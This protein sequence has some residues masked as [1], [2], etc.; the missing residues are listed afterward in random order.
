MVTEEERQW[1]WQ[2]Y[3]PEPRMRLN[4]GIRRRLAPLLD[5]DRRLIQLANSLLFSLPGTPIIYYGDEIGMGDDIWLF[6]RNGVRTP[7]QWE[8]IP[9]AGFSQAAAEKLFAPVI[10][11]PEFGPSKV[12][13]KDQLSQ[14]GS[15]Y[16]VIRQMIAI[17]KQHPLFGTGGFD[18]A[19]SDNAAVAAY[20]RM[21]VEQ[22]LLV[23]NNLSPDRQELEVRLDEKVRLNWVDLLSHRL[24][25]V[26]ARQNLSVTLEPY[27][28]LWLTFD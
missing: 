14:S 21:D 1:M 11:S 3:A 10:A 15:L 8:N 7:M 18:W 27:E 16:L 5:N 2:E 13:V 4:L 6:D 20:W 25:S 9:N 17:R 26:P 12:N 24:G 19:D 28:Y 22:R 23:L